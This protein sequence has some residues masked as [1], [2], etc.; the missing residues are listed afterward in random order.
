MNAL[1]ATGAWLGRPGVERALASITL[2]A[3]ALGHYYL[4]RLP[5]PVELAGRAPFTASAGAELVI[6][7]EAARPGLLFVFEG[8]PGEGVDL[9]L[10]R[11]SLAPATARLFARLGIELPGGDHPAS[12][13]TGEARGAKTFLAIGLAAAGPAPA[14]ALGSPLEPGDTG[15]AL[16]L[17][18]EAAS[19][20]VRALSAAEADTPPPL[21]TLRLAGRDLPL[22]GALPVSLI[23]APGSETRLRIVS[24]GSGVSPLA[25]VPA[26]HPEAALAARALGARASARGPYTDLACA[27][28]SGLPLARPDRLAEGLCPEGEGRLMLQ[29]LELGPGRIALQATGRAWLLRNGHPVTLDLLGLLNGNPVLAALIGSLDAAALAWIWR[30]FRRQ[31]Q[32]P[33]PP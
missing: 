22:S 21:R 2:V 9:R 8:A 27:A 15:L 33:A 1:S 29:T 20:E 18:T 6:R 32:A 31:P 7:P 26:E 30:A 24:P 12:L 16:T 17:R 19:L 13:L 14:L 4:S 23:A 28:D 3:L 11:A 10:A 25:L 5:L